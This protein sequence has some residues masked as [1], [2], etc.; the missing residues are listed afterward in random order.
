[1]CHLKKIRVELILQ[2]LKGDYYNFLQTNIEFTLSN[3]FRS[4]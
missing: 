1:M 2:N 3:T 4:L